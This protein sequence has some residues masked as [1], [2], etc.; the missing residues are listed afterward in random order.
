MTIIIQSVRKETDNG[1]LEISHNMILETW[2]RL[3]PSAAQK[4]QRNDLQV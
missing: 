2:Q 4:E 1:I 3:Y